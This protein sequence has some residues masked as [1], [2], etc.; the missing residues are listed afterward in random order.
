MSWH[1]VKVSSPPC[2]ITPNKTRTTESFRRMLMPTK[3]MMARSPRINRKK[4]RKMLQWL[5]SNNPS[6]LKMRSLINRKKRKMKK[7]TVSNRRTRILRATQMQMRVKKIRFW[8]EQRVKL[9]AMKYLASPKRRGHNHNEKKKAFRLLKRKI[10]LHL[11]LSISRRKVLKSH[12]LPSIMTRKANLLIAA[13]RIARSLRVKAITCRR[14]DLEK[15]PLPNN[16]NF[17]RPQ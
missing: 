11:Y 9:T 13:R 15:Y 10:R 2:L 7:K 14:R 12:N 6:E 5:T 16:K 3:E 8:P 1:L 17:N 4:K